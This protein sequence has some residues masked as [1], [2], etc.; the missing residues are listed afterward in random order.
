LKKITRIYVAGYRYDVRFLRPCIQSI[1][2]WYPDIRITL[3]K[4]R[5]YGD[6]STRALEKACK[7]DVLE[8]G[9]RVFGWGFGKLEPLFH[10]GSERFLV[11]DSDILF[12]GPVLERLEECD[13][14]F[15]VQDEHD[16]EDAFILSHYYDRE[17]LREIDKDFKFPG[18]TFNTGQWVGR[19][20]LVRRE[21]FASLVHD[22]NP[23]RIKHGDVFKL[24]EQGLLNYFLVKGQASGRWTL[25]PLRFMEV[26]TNAVVE[27][28]SLDEMA[29]GKGRGFLV[30]WCGCRA[31][32]F[33]RMARGDLWLHFE[34]LYYNRFRLPG[35]AR[36]LDKLRG[37][38]R[39]RVH[40]S[41]KRPLKHILGMARKLV[42][43][44]AAG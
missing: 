29:A 37:P 6:Y 41:V 38:A 7:C 15:V 18:F 44:Q 19:A 3:I 13:D 22:S 4:D 33:R 16:P 36:W 27:T 1:R 23:P 14:D 30:H 5:F 11:I 21:D 9:N 35:L 10:A 8:C 2:T 24:G 34:H 40:S 17:K 25:K 20:G 32:D 26:G 12:V 42:S 28:L 43:R 39:D 31:D